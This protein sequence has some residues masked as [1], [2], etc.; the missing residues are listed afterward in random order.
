MES[1]LAEGQ[2]ARTTPSECTDLIFSIVS[3]HDSENLTLYALDG[4]CK[5]A[6][7]STTIIEILFHPCSCLVGL[8]MSGMNSTNC[9]SE[10]H[11]KICQYVEKCD[12]HTGLATCPTASFQSLDF[13]HQRHRPV[14][15]FGLPQ[16]SF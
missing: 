9:T 4:P 3:P 6:D 10:C 14:W 16:L 7:L 1:G 12:S 13:L 15:L 11:G 5:N 2:L 8:Q